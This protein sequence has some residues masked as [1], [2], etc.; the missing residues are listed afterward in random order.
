MSS[1]PPPDSAYDPRTSLGSMFL[2]V[3]AF[4]L[5]RPRNSVVYA[6]KLKYADDKHAPPVIGKGLFDWTPPLARLHEAEMV[7][8]IGL[9]AIVFLRFTKM[10]RNLFAIV[11]VIAVAIIMPANLIT[12]KKL[13]NAFKDKDFWTI[14]SPKY[15]TESG[16]WVHVVCAWVINVVVAFFLWRNYVA[17]TRLRRGYFE[18]AEYLHS[19]H[20]RT[21]MFTDIP[22]ASRTDEGILRLADEC[23]QTGDLPRA[24]I[25]RNVKELPELIEN[26]EKAVKEL[27]SVLAKYLKNPDRLPANRP[28]IKPKHRGGR[29]DAIDFLTDRISEIEL[30]I[31]HVRESIDKRNPMPYGFASWHR[32]ED[33]HSIAY[34]ARNKHPQGTTIRL[35]PKPSDLIW[36]NLGLS[37]K[38]RSWKRLL[39]NFWILILTIA[40]I[41]PNAMI[42]IF[43]SNLSNLAKVW[44]GFN[45]TYQHHPTDWAIVQGIAS[46]ALTSLIYVLLPIAFRRLS[47]HAGDRTKT[48]REKHVT[49]KLYA[50]FVFN[51]LVVFSLFSS[52]WIF[53]TAVI[54]DRKPNESVWQAMQEG[55]FFAKMLAALVKTSPFW[56]SWLLQRNLGSAADLA[57]MIQLFWV[58]YGKK[59]T[60]PT[61]RQLIELTAPLAFDY[62]VYYN[63]FLFYA[64]VALCF[65]TVQPLVIPITAFYFTID[66]WLKKYLLLYVLITKNESGGQFWRIL[67]NRMIFA[68]ILA[69]IVMACAI[70]ANGT[71]VQVAILA[72]LPILLIGF[73]IYCARTFDDQNNFYNK[74]T[75]VDPENMADP[76][77]KSRRTD[78]VASKFG[79]PAL[80]A[81]LMTPM[82]HAKA[83][84]AISQIYRGR[85]ANPAAADIHN[86][87]RDMDTASI[88]SDSVGYPMDPMSQ[89]QPGKSARFAPSAQSSVKRKD[90]FELI[91]ENKLDFGYYKNRQEFA[92]EYGGDGELFGHPADLVSE[93]SG[94][95]SSFFGHSR[96]GS[97]PTDSRASSPGPYSRPG[98]AGGFN[99]GSHS[100]SGSERLQQIHPAYRDGA[101]DAPRPGLY[102]GGS[103]NNESETNLLRGAQAPGFAEEEGGEVYGMDRWR[104]GGSGYVG[105]PAGGDEV[106]EGGYGG[107]GRAYGEDAGTGYEAYRHRR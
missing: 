32:I 98:T 12:G 76:G 68:T 24:A 105:L 41:A 54:H 79:H 47:I 96:D 21:L 52:L 106:G 74:A 20:A 100:R 13:R 77:K 39:N 2:I 104:T 27:E 102:R 81:K 64:T 65:T 17:V 49:T 6:P 46:P 34:G 89:T 75:L 78:R 40:W 67:F 107:G 97:S 18:S 28:T 103:G 35:A 61:P 25:A 57:Q 85:M 42:A 80:Y 90:L 38:D 87:N 53:I 59:F 66:Y 56:L 55:Y 3:A 11:T 36:K 33:A 37:K 72:P 15:A 30:E 23:A 101:G 43:L 60:S 7:G 58:W 84:N 50:F 62:A 94:T 31:N 51:N 26:H 48:S 9:D 83:Q 1:I 93:R 86:H 69:D 29:V 8:K 19:L 22:P 45:N 14:S 82:V 88:Y 16:L 95:P 73:K 70:K 71:W 99:G 4:C 44:K 91:P 92:D 5:I 63:Y 10:C